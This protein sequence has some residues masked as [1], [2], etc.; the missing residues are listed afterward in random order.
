MQGP[1]RNL[2][3]RPGG[4]VVKTL[5]TDDAKMLVKGKSHLLVNRFAEFPCKYSD[6]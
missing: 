3:S 2:S 6:F 5:K 1:V 4:P